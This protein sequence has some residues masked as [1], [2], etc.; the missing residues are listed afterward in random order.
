LN[1]YLSIQF[2]HPFTHLPNHFIPYHTHQL[3]H[4]PPLHSLTHSLTPLSTQSIQF[5]DPSIHPST[6]PSKHTLYI[7][8]YISNFPS[9]L[10]RSR[11]QSYPSIHIYARI[12]IR[13]HTRNHH[14]Y[15]CILA[16]IHTHNIPIIKKSPTPHYDDSPQS[17]Q[18]YLIHSTR[19][20]F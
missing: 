13:I 4:S 19:V 14:P 12:C 8:T 9:M 16:R 6:Y 18:T 1:S 17:Y 20:S 7:H 5:T 10:V 3:I 2:I 15:Q 11:S